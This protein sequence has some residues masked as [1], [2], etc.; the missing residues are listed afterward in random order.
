VCRK[1]GVYYAK[2]HACLAVLQKE[3]AVKKTAEQ[4]VLHDLMMDEL[5]QSCQSKLTKPVRSDGESEERL[6]SIF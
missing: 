3:K 6:V 5:Y 4:Q 2:R 1:C